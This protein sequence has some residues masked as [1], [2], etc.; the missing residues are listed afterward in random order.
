VAERYRFPEG[1]L[2]DVAWLAA[3]SADV[4]AGRI[5]VLDATAQLGAPTPQ[6]RY[7]V[8]SGRPLWEEEHLPG[9]RHADLLDELSDPAA[10]YHFSVAGEDR[11]GAALARLGVHDGTL[12]VCYDS[13]DGSWAARLWW[14]LRDLGVPAVVLDGGLSAWRAA[15]QPVTDSPA[16]PPPDGPP[17]RIRTDRRG[18]ASLDDV[19]AIVE[20][21][22][23]GALV[24]ALGEGQ[25]T[26]A[27]P[28][29]YPR[30]GHIP[31]SRNL[32]FGGLRAQ[33]GTLRPRAELRAAAEEVV[34]APGA[35]PLTLYC[36]MGVSAA[37]LALGLVA[38][39][40]EDLRIYDGSLEEWTAD[41]ERALE[42]G[43]AR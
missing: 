8:A 9:S 32:P 22:R 27:E 14:L 23:P 21:R 3:R 37:G 12:V 42:T 20:G 18:W 39:G 41:P 19:V 29:R 10:P 33:D 24:C 6:E 17:V 26:G 15:G 13:G 1:P 40:Y 16:A 25:F 35:T 43:P 30:Q 5:V 28:T 38:A 31:G 36:G 7:P 11:L 4:E 34:G 2:V